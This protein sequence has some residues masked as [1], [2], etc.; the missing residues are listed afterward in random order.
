[1]TKAD[2]KHIWDALDAADTEFA[3][4]MAEREWYVTDVIDQI[5]SAKEIVH[6]QLKEMK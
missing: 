6:S 4:L 3:E 5:H 2:L 1:M